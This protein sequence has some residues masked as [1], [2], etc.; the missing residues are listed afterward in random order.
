MSSESF[1]TSAA[2]HYKCH[3]KSLAGIA[4]PVVFSST[5]IVDDSD[6]SSRLAEKPDSAIVDED[7]FFYSR[8]GSPTNQVVCEMVTNLEGA[9]GTFAFC[10]GMNAITTVLMT[11]LKSGDHVI[12][13]R[14]VYSGTYVWLTIWGPRMNIDVTFVDA[15]DIDNYKEA[16]RENT[17]LLYCES[18]ANPT[19][20]VTDI[21]ALGALSAS[22]SGKTIC[23]CDATFATPYLVNPLSYNG[24]DVVIHSATKY[25]GGHSDLTAGTVSSKN[26]EFLERLGKAAK[27]FGGPL[28]AMDSY[29]LIR[30]MKTLDVRME[31]HSRNAL[32]VAEFLDS[33]PLV[34]KCH[35]PG[36]ASHPD[37]ALATRQFTAGHGYGGMLSF[38]VG[39][40]AR[41][42]HIVEN[43]KLVNLAVS[44]GAVESLIEHPASMTHAMVPPDEKELAGITQGLIRLSVGLESA[45]DLIADLEKAL[46]GCGRL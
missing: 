2:K 14:A 31:R 40:L 27:L 30:G 45:E 28:P 17:R 26:K 44:L 38:D 1:A 4:P 32:R 5:F 6:H 29:L 22:T 36:L 24:I 9:F 39:D 41:G 25:L 23:C 43:V 15:T 11:E 42:K 19:M 12:A 16:M 20:R 21:E 7:G 34:L 10:S 46:A 3:P 8:W 37:H 35:Y 18:P 13:P 33:H